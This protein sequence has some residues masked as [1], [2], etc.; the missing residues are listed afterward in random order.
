M[1]TGLARADHLFLQVRRGDYVVL[2]QGVR[3]D[4]KQGD[5][6]TSNQCSNRLLRTKRHIGTSDVF[7]PEYNPKSVYTSLI[8]CPGQ[9]YGM[10]LVGARAAGPRPELS[11]RNF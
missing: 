8:G 5:K 2:R 11:G 6:Q 7:R 1:L 4:S 10:S 3:G 9:R